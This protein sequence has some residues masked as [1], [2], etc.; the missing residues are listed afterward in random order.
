MWYIYIL[1]HSKMFEKL[2]KVDEARFYF[3]NAPSKKLNFVTGL[4]FTGQRKR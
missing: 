1:N 4:K 3:F 2:I